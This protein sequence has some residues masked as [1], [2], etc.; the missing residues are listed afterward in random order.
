LVDRTEHHDDRAAE[1][2]PHVEVEVD[3][4]LQHLERN[5]TGDQRTCGDRREPGQVRLRARGSGE[6][7]ARDR[8]Q[9]QPV[10]LVPR[11]RQ[12]GRLVTELHP[13]QEERADQ[14]HTHDR[15][16]T[17]CPTR[18]PFVHAGEANTILPSAISRTIRGRSTC[19][20]CWIRAWS[21]TGVSPAVTGTAT[22]ARIGP[23]ST[24]ASTTWTV[25]PLSRAPA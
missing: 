24:E 7:R 3:H 18:E 22:C 20:S 1:H 11:D 16:D 21:V 2:Q 12:A 17:V 15:K 8:D 4:P 23:P 14:H 19:S 10:L 13:R 25:T 6:H 5:V 9:E